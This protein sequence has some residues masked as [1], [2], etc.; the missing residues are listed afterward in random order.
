MRAEQI[1]D[2]AVWFPI[3]YGVEP[4]SSAL[5]SDRS[6]SSRFLRFR[7]IESVHDHIPHQ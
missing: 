7:F 2:S 1:L 4:A 5:I 6:S 3:Y